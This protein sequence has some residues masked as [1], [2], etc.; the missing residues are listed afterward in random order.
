[1]RCEILAKDWILDI[2][3]F[4]KVANCAFGRG[5]KKRRTGSRG[6]SQKSGMKNGAETWKRVHHS[7]QRGKEKSR[8]TKNCRRIVINL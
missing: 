4:T 6:K 7:T 1:V 3:T 5:E 2:R 8:Q